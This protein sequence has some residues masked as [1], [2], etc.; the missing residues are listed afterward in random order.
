M[1]S[2]D[3]PR[4]NPERGERAATPSLL[5]SFGVPQFR[6]LW[7]ANV[8]TSMAMAMGMLTTGWL[9]LE[10]TDSP[11]WVGVAAGVTGLGQVGF[12]VFGGVLADRV[13]RRKALILVQLLTGLLALAL[14]LLTVMDRIALWAIL[15]LLFFRGAT[16]AAALPLNNSLTY[17]TVGRRLILNAMAARLSAMNLTRI[18]GGILAGVLI[19][20]VGTGGTFLFIA[21]VIFVSPLPL[22]FM[23]GAYR[24]VG[25]S[26]PIWRTAQGGV[27][28]ALGNRPLRS[29]LLMSLLMEMFGFSY[30]IM[31]PVIARDV[32]EVGASGLGFLSAA[33]GI[34][35]MVGTLSV[36]SLGDFRAKGLLLVL[37]GGGAGLFLLLFGLSPW[38]SASLVLAA[39]VGTTLMAYDSF[40]AALLALASSDAMRGRVMGLYG[41]TFGFTPLGGFVAGVVASIVSAP[42]AVGL[43]GVI[44]LGYAARMLRGL[45]S[46][47]EETE[48]ADQATE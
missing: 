36:A 18:L 7:T 42:F 20:T 48:A 35:A 39:L 2:P 21:G 9:V 16:M 8:F 46:F 3:S 14:G 11:L 1:Q 12:A 28:Y 31:L 30:H 25:P 29:L 24:T 43:G 10:V 38:F 13:D 33:G 22:L 34:G 26:E 6:W 44:I 23:R 5:A 40:M 41:F 37:T 45:H 47:E 17:D 15:F 19:S 4:L 32:L 27:K